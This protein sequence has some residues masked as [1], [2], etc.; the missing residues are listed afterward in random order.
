MFPRTN[1]QPAI[2]SE[3]SRHQ[4]VATDI[5]FELRLPVASISAWVSAFERQQCK[6]Q[7]STNTATRFAVKH[8]IGSHECVACAD[9]EVDTRA[10]TVSMRPTP[11]LEFR[12]GIAP[13]VSLHA[14]AYLVAPGVGY[15]SAT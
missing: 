5:A 13:N 7:P 8:D 9:S 11:Y 10:Q 6:K 15:G 4:G 12:P 14:G 2:L 1:D 3:S